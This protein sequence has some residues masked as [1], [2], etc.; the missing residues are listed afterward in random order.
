MPHFIKLLAV[1]LSFCY[2]PSGIRC[3]AIPILMAESWWL[4][5]ISFPLNLNLDI[6]TRR[7]AEAHEHV[8]RLGIGLQHIDQAVVRANFK[9]LV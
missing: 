2:Q 4:M 7:E 8:N 1:S 6:H 9:V 5:A 3:S